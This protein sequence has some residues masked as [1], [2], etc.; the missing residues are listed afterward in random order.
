MP[1]EPQADAMKRLEVSFFNATVDCSILSL[2]DRFQSLGE[3][4]SH[5]GVLLNFGQL[6]AQTRSDQC[7]LLGDKLTLR[8]QADID[9]S[10]LATEMESLPEL[11]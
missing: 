5:F 3:V 6:D 7:K 2:E 8:E 1:D 4:R 11:P 9:G 10:A